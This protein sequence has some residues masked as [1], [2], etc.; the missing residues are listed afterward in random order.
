MIVENQ[1]SLFAR[2]CM[3]SPICP[4]EVTMIESHNL[5]QQIKRIAKDAGRMMLTM[6]ASQIHFKGCNNFASEVDLS[7]EHFIKKQLLTITPKIAIF[8][9]ETGGAKEA[10]TRWIIDP[11]DGTNNFIHGIPHYAVSIALQYEGDI[12]LG[13]TYDPNRDELFSALKNH[14][15]YLNDTAIQTSSCQ[16]LSDAIIGTGFPYD[17]NTKANFYLKSFGNVLRQARGIRRFG[18]AT[19]DLAYL[20]MGRIDGFWEYHLQPWDVA[21]GALLIQE[22]GGLCTQMN[23]APLNINQPQ[24]LAGS[25]L[26]LWTELKNQMLLLPESIIE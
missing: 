16:Q 11:L 5:L 12:I 24:I 6:T 21:V 8:A 22:A 19:L 17:H 14:G 10:S 4:Q 20:A 9:E 1:L 25:T 2:F 3:F 13:V 18:A 15:A 7:V 23:G 26:S